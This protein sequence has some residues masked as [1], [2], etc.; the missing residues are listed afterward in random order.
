MKKSL[1]VLLVVGLVIVALIVSLVK[2]YNNMVAMEEGVTAQWSQVENVYQ[3]R[4]DKTNNLVKI[5]E[6][7]ANFEK[8][9]LTEVVNA[10]AKATSVNVD[11]TKLTAE[12]IQQFKQAQ[13]AFG[14]TLGKLLVVV[15]KYPELK[16]TE[17]FREFQAQYEG[18]ENRIAVERRKFS[19]TAQSFNTYI[20]K[21]PKNI[22][23]GMFNFEK[24]AYFEAEKSAQ[25]A[26]EINFQ[27]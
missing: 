17:N 19:E 1:V 5:V 9:T 24:K 10:R 18:M 21:F 7:S 26:P 27:N 12:S 23:A 16:S 13:D 25:K 14:Q 4:M 20:R 15:E 22:I 11:P 2:S 6:A 8:S 3:S